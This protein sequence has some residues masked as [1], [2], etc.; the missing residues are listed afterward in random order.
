MR[1]KP[2]QAQRPGELRRPA[3]GSVVRVLS[4]AGAEP[5][6]FLFG[7]VTGAVPS[8]PAELEFRCTDITS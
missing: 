6:R 2:D 8:A 4:E 5:P 7:E 3:V 1:T